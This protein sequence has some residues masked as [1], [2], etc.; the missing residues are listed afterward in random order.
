MIK[1]ETITPKYT[2]PDAELKIGTKEI[3]RA[4]FSAWYESCKDI[5]NKERRKKRKAGKNNG[6]SQRDPV[7]R[8]RL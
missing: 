2:P 1:H 5:Y 3:R 4:Y 8:K 7:S 6:N